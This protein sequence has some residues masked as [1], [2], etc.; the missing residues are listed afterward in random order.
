MRRF[1][2]KVELSGNTNNFDNVDNNGIGVLYVDG[3]KR[4]SEKSVIA[5]VKRIASLCSCKVE[6]II[7]IN[8]IK[9]NG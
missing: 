5:S 2:V 6:K 8:E 1:S 4:T 7:S 3:N 9:L